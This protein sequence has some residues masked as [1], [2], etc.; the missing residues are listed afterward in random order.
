M[1]S[2]QELIDAANAQ[3]SPGISAME[4]LARGYLNGQQQSLER[5]KTLIM[6]EQ[7]RRDQE[8]KMREHEM[9][10]KNQERLSAQM[11]A[12][13]DANRQQA[14]KGA[15]AP[16]EPSLPQQKI[17]QEWNI[18]EKGQVSEK[19]KVAPDDSGDG[20]DTELKQARLDLIRAQTDAAKYRREIGG[21]T[22]DVNTSNKL[23]QEFINR[24]EVKEYV[25]VATSVK[26]MDSLLNKA[27]SGD[28]KSKLAIDQ[29][30]ITIYNKISDPTSV[31]RESEYARTPENVPV[32]NRIAGAIEKIKSGGS[33]ITDEDRK[34]L[35]V[36]AKILANERGATF[37]SRRDEY[38][39][40]SNLSGADPNLVI[41]TIP[42]FTPY[43]LQNG[44]ANGNQSV[45]GGLP[46]GTIKKGY[47]FVGG[48]PSEKGSWEQIQ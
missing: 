2:V 39:N 41:G 34:A 43:D 9:M 20:F 27:L 4:G 42:D 14:F 7:N 47:R 11:A 29:G 18:N 13:M 38:R 6:L 17:T 31:V 21:K 24:P 5:A 3:K 30:L 15:G 36:G 23:R 40:I 8:M 35:V 28:E 32:V 1:A 45:G 22:F 26:S 12:Q 19:M 37:Q 44:G 33:G 10:V 16:P 46:I 25:T 48:N